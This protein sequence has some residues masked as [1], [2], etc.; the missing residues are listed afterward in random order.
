M[1]RFRHHPV[2]RVQRLYPYHFYLLLALIDFLLRGS[3]G[4]SSV[5]LPG[6]VFPFPQYHNAAVG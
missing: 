4:I 3:G 2:L 6:P 1:G 5:R